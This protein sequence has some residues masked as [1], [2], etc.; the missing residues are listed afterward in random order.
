M[1]IYKSKWQRTPNNKFREIKYT[2]TYLIA[3]MKLRI[4]H[5]KMSHGY[6]MQREKPTLC[7]T[8]GEP[9]SIKQLNFTLSKLCYGT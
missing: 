2:F 4:D 3:K 6:L 7:Q 9:L 8:Y 1:N 5:S